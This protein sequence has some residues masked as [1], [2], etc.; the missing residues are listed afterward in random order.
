MAEAISAQARRGVEWRLNPALMVRELFG[1]EP[2]LWQREALEAFPHCPRLAMQACAGPGKTA[3]LAWLGWNFMLTRPHPMI[4]CTSSTGDNLRINLWTEL[5][6]WHAKSELLQALFEVQKTT[7]FAK[8]APNTW[9]MEARTWPKDAGDSQLGAALAGL[10]SK[11]VMWLLDETGDYPQAILPVCEGIF[12]GEPTEAHI[13]QAG[14]PLKLSGPLY[15]ASRNRNLWKV[16]EITADPDDPKRTPRVSV[17]TAREMI[18]QYGRD[19]AWVMSR[20]FGKF[21]PSSINALIGPEEM[22]AAQLRCWSEHDVQLHARV[23]GVDV[24]REGDDA[25][26]M[27]P[28]QGLIAYPPTMWRNLNGIEGAGLL[29]RKVQEWDVDAV[30]IDATGGFGASW[31]D[32]MRLLGHSPVGVVFSAVPYDRRFYNKRAE[33]Y[34]TAAQWIKDGGQLPP[35]PELVRAMTQTTYTHRNDR[36]LIEDKAQLKERIGMSPDH[37][38][39]FVQ[40]FAEDVK[41]KVR[42]PGNLEARRNRHREREWSPFEAL[43]ERERM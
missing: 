27:F 42:L 13:V 37:A 8:E 18:A 17:K 6:R 20:I 32:C 33:M 34:Y 9:K 2:D 24:A 5:A 40:T 11:Y 1:V 16:I 22:E 30:F 15:H 29:A 19:N 4:G 31:I 41:R 10:H 35:C 43:Y 14:N 12:S 38:D 28:R 39:A 26:V 7:I 36:L 21:P 3:V 23:L 25:S